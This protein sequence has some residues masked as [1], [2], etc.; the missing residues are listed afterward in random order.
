MKVGFVT[1]WFERGQAYV[2]HMLR[3]VV[4]REHECYVFARMGGVYGMPKQE[5]TGFW[6][7]P[8][9]TTYPEYRIAPPEL[10][11]WIG[12]NELDV[13]IFNEEYDWSLP[14]TVG[15]MGVKSVTYLDYCKPDWLP[16]LERFYDAVLCSNKRSYDLVKDH[17]KAHYMGW[18]VDAELF[19]PADAAMFTFFHNAGWLGLNYR[20]NTPAAVKAYCQMLEEWGG[21]E[22]GLFIHAQVDW[23]KL[24]SETQRLIHGEETICYFNETVPA[25]GKYHMGNCLLFPTKLEGLGLPLFE[26]LACGLPVITTDAPPMNEFLQDGVTGWLVPVKETLARADGISFPETLIDVDALAKTML[27]IARCPL[28][29]AKMGQWAREYAETAL[30]MDKLAAKVNEVLRWL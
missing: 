29:T 20:K 5:T 26:A 23:D 9:L 3:E 18:A 24:P 12:H 15:L 28:L 16:A 7:V 30:S 25:P 21:V 4:S 13:V 6:D 17:C 8:N 14:R 2:T 27:Q 10:A 1:M 11:R 22:P 19:R